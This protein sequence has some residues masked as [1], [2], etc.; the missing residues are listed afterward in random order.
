MKS[1]SQN[2]LFSFLLSFVAVILAGIIHALWTTV[3]GAVTVLLVG[4]FSIRAVKLNFPVNAGD[5]PAGMGGM[6]DDSFLNH[7]MQFQINLKRLEAV[8]GEMKIFSEDF[9]RK[10]GIMKDAAVSVASAAEEMSVSSVSVASAAEESTT[11]I[12][13]ISTNT[14]EMISTINE[15]A[16]N[17]ERTRNIAAQAVQKVDRATEKVKSLENKAVKINKIIDVIQDIADQTKLLALN[18][19]IEAA[20]AGEAGKGFAV[21][22]NE[23]KELARQTA[24]ATEDIKNSVNDIQISTSDTAKE[25][26][27]INEIIAQVDENVASIAT[28]VEEQNAVTKQISD[29]IAQAANGLEEVNQSI[30][31]NAEAAGLVAQDIVKVSLS[32]RQIEADSSTFGMNIDAVEEINKQLSTL[33]EA[34]QLPSDRAE[35]IQQIVEVATLLRDREYDHLNWVKKVQSAI[36]QQASSIDVQKDPSLCEMGKFL[37]SHRRQEIESRNPALREIFNKMETP[38]ARLHQS[39]IRLEEMLKDESVPAIEIENFYQS[40]TVGILNELLELFHQAINI[41]YNL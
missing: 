34:Y 18:A 38:H 27:G 13:V 41:S 17:S 26:M 35:K 10:A 16:R 37:M 30:A 28:A 29:G 31:K 32:A 6:A 36:T 15:I 40:T 9:T 8:K 20:R 2:L 24:E 4:F 3:I 22:A 7:L 11:N 14:K 21:V 5:N 23:V 39:A 19:T 33:M 25:I 12:G 1:I